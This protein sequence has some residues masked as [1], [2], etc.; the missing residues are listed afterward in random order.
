MDRTAALAST[1]GQLQD[2][3][4][5]P[6]PIPLAAV[7]DAIGSSYSLLFAERVTDGRVQSPCVDGVDPAYGERLKLAAANDLLPSWLHGLH[8]GT[9]MDRA[10]L[11]RDGDFRRSAFFDFVVRPE[12]RFHCLITT[13]YVTPVQ[14]FH[15]IVGRPAAREDFS[16]DDLR[17][18]RA[19]LP[20]V[21]ALIANGAALDQVQAG[22]DALSSTL[23]RLPEAI[24]V[25]SAGCRL[26]FAN[27]EARCLLSVADGLAVVRGT[28]TAMT[29]CSQTALRK[30]VDAVIGRTGEPTR[31]PVQLARPSAQA[32]L[33]V[34]VMPLRDPDGPTGREPALA[35]LRIRRGQPVMGADTGRLRRHFGLTPKEGELVGQLTQGLEL[36]AAATSLGVSYHTARHHLRNVFAK[37]DTHRQSELVRLA[38]A[39]G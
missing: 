5:V 31:D 15:M 6:Q 2:A 35:M 14:R 12:G 21:G 19:L 10:S 24:I 25:V 23:D 9:V 26:V 3:A 27:K 13:P 1:L 34:E 7:S 37:T 38:L 4:C 36:R 29:P 22:A 33:S 32:A 20:H 17:V 28:V 39:G 18:L 30:A 11:Q 8:P 16:S